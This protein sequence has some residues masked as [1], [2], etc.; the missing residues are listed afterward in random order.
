MVQKF[1]KIFFFLLYFTIISGQCFSLKILVA[2]GTFPSLT[3]TFVLNQITGLID[4]GHDVYIHAYREGSHAKVQESVQHYNLLQRTYYGTLPSDLQSY[5]V[6]L[7]QFGTLGVY[8]SKIKK[9]RQLPAKLVTCFRG[10]DITRYLKRNPGAYDRLL[11]EGDFFLPVCEVFKNKITNLGCSKEK[12]EVVHSSID[13]SKF[14]FLT[15]SA[16]VDKVIKI[17]TVA[18]IVGKKGHEYVIRAL[19]KVAQRFSNFEYVIV[20]DGKGTLK[21]LLKNLSKELGIEKK[22]RFVGQYTSNEVA[23]LLKKSHLFVLPSVTDHAGDQ[24]GIPNALKEAMAMGMPVVSTYHS[25]IPELI[26]DGIEGFLVP[27]RDVDN[28]AEKIEYLCKNPSCWASMGRA[29]R[30]KIKQEYDSD[31]IKLQLHQVLMNLVKSEN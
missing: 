24:E 8:F 26:T 2:V 15:R 23:S 21:T 6:V 30:L 3:H 11:R 29:G 5:D 9:N 22:V 13:C 28:L 20:G 10:N 16:P 18:R 27:E 4:F 12:I 14:P 1:F 19:G 25:G 17:V 7:C 31:K